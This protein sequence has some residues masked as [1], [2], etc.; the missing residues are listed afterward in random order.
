MLSAAHCAWYALWSINDVAQHTNGKGGTHSM[1]RK[2]FLI[3]SLTLA[4]VFVSYVQAGE[5]PLTVASLVSPN[6]R[7]LVF[8]PHPDDE[9]LGTGGLIQRVLSAGG[10]VKVVF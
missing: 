1:A 10:T 8:S 9:T 3:V 6:T 4:V 2:S 5:G 7:L